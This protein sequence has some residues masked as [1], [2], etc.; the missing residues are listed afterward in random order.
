[1]DGLGRLKI[2]LMKLGFNDYLPL[3]LALDI[4]AFKIGSSELNT[5]D[6]LTH[7]N[8]ELSFA[9]PGS[10]AARDIFA[11]KYLTGFTCNGSLSLLVPR[12]LKGFLSGRKFVSP[13]ITQSAKIEH[14][15]AF[16]SLSL[17]YTLLA[18]VAGS[19]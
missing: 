13:L 12:Q 14:N 16:V 15:Q 2:P 19:A 4:C 1:M 8:S 6:A 3:L 11:L 10:L 5:P 18:L 9:R 7:Q 17:G